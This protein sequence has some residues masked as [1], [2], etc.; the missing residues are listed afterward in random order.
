MRSYHLLAYGALATTLMAAATLHGCTP[1]AAENRFVTSYGVSIPLGNGS[2]RSYVV[3]DGD[4]PVEV[5]VALSRDALTGLPTDHSPGGI[6]MPDGHHTFDYILD[7]PEENPT[8]FRFVGLGWNPA[9]HEPPGIYDQPHFD[10]HFFTVSME[11][12][13]AIH[14]GDP[15]FEA[16]AA[17]HPEPGH[18]PAGYV[19]IPG[20]VP[21]MGAH[22]VDPTSPELNGETFTTTFLY[23]SWDGVLNFA[24]PMITVAYLQTRPD[25]RIPVGTAQRYSPAGYYPS[26]YRIRWD[27]GAQEYRVALAGLVYRN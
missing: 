19:A 7:M 4:I 21:L 24:E 15:D 12:R 10:F 13:D 23:G 6:P 25:V 3:T 27:S 9:G 2:A 22:W 8:P 17:R 26:E 18:T 16:K 14:P 11:E 1:A 5:G 20:G